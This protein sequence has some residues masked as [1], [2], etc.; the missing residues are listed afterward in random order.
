MI[1]EYK[2][3]N[4]N[5]L[6]MLLDNKIN[7]LVVKN[8]ITHDL[9]RKLCV[10]L[11]DNDVKGYINAP[12]IG[13]IGMAFYETENKKELLEKYF[14]IA[15]ENIQIL[16]NKCYP[17]IS[18]MDI[19]RCRLDEIWSAGSMIESIMGK[20]MFVGLAR[21]VKPNITFLA[22]HDIFEK[23]APE[24]FRAKSLISQIAC[25]VYLQMPENGGELIIWEKELLPKVFDDLR[26]DSYGI[27]IDYLGEPSHI[28]KPEIGDLILFNSKKMHAISPGDSCSRF[29]LSCFIGYRGKHQ[30]LSIWS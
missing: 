15:D 10:K 5:S 12:S 9:C 3:F 11:F 2:D 29:S 18:P 25:N 7:Y 26:K 30:S 8:F 13:R 4:E 22:H 1:L 19:L 20:K 17:L 16:R 21:V 23:D 28:I 24:S 6:S 14:S 27:S